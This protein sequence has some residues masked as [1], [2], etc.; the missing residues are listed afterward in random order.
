MAENV[1]L[2]RRGRIALVTINRPDK[3]NALNIATRKDL[4]DMLDELRNDE[5]TRVV[6]IT[7]AGEKA[8]VAGADIN[9]FAGRTP[10]QPRA[11]V[12]AR[13]G[14]ISAADFPK[15]LIPLINRFC[16]GGGCALGLSC[17]HP[18]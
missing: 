8:F 17:D 6:V 7:G 14:F 2:E 18:L 5:E 4:A 9:E 3:L 15:P 10:G 1:L 11:G 13:K 16:L 12:K